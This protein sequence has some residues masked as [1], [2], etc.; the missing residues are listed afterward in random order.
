MSL[1][2]RSEFPLIFWVC[3]GGKSIFM[4]VAQNS[5]KVQYTHVA[6][7]QMRQVET[8]SVISALFFRV[9]RSQS[10]SKKSEI[11]FTNKMLDGRGCCCMRFGG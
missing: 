9:L 2:V 3:H 10:R 4:G 1:M 5:V 7:L 11:G 8:A 6:F